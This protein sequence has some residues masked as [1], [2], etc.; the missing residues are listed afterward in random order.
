MK[1]QT[2][3]ASL[4]LISASAL[5]TSNAF[6]QKIPDCGKRTPSKTLP[7]PS[8]S[9]YDAYRNAKA[10]AVAGGPGNTVFQNREGKLPAAGRNEVYY[11]Y[12]LGYDGN[13]GP[14]SHRAVLLVQ[15]AK[16]KRRLMERYYTQDHYETFCGLSD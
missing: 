16:A 5:L 9:E 2:V 1:A 15:E 12:Y 10:S 8:D 11:E 6:A 13:N 4:F 7:T 3:L 14:G